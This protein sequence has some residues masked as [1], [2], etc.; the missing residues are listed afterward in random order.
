MS[1][2]I[3]KNNL[4]IADDSKTR[5]AES[6]RVHGESLTQVLKMGHRRPDYRWKP[7]GRERNRLLRRHHYSRS[8]SGEFPAEARVGFNAYPR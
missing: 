6:E 7:A 1:V 2:F 5:Y 3:T 8:I 4:R